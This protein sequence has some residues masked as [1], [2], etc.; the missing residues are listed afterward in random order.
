MESYVLLVCSYVQ[1]HFSFSSLH[2]LIQTSVLM[3]INWRDTTHFDCDYDYHTGCR[4]INHC[5][6]QQS[7]SGLH[8]TGHPYST[9]L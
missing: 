5:Q 8:S 3:T 7:Y 4:N 1:G 2:T 6:Q 9:H